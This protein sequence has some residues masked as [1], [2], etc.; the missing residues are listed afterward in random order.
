MNDALGEVPDQG[1]P[2]TYAKRHAHCD[3]LVAGAGPAGLAAALVAG[4]AGARVIIADENT[5]LGG[6]LVVGFQPIE[7]HALHQS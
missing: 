4:A 7:G 2:D 5:S 6:Q 1:D 3:L